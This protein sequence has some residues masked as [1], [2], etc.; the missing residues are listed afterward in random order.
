[1]TK[2]ENLSLLLEAALE[3]VDPYQAVKQSIQLHLPAIQQARK[4]YVVGCGKAVV[5]MALAVEDVLGESITRGV[6][7]TKYGHLAKGMNQYINVLEAAHPVPDRAG[8]EAT[9]SVLDVLREA[10]E[11]DI[12]LALISGG[13]SALWVQPPASVS[14]ED[15]MQV[16]SLLLQSGAAINEMNTVRK[17]LS[18]IKGG[19]A[20]VEAYPARVFAYLISDVVGDALDVI[21]SG[22][23][24]PDST[25]FSDA[26]A[27][28]DRYALAGKMP[29]SVMAHLKDGVRGILPDTPRDGDVVFERVHHEI[30]S[31]NRLAVEAVRIRAEA[32]GYQ[33]VVRDEPLVG[34]A[35]EAAHDFTQHLLSLRGSRPLCFIAGGET[36][37]TLGDTPGKGGRNQEFALAAAAGIDGYAVHVASLATDGNDGPTDAAGAHVDGKTWQG[38]LALG[39]DPEKELHQHN[40]YPLLQACGALLMTGPTNTNVADIQIG[41]VD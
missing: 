23:F 22:P 32:L 2:H 36:T 1:M 34:E 9:T 21:A 33:V 29:D 24:A 40:A 18:C 12:V 30:C 13:G 15:K 39:Y 27:I 31:A 35:V 16:S 17:H 4:V 6:V 14:L 10:Q 5:P 25:S 26:I 19:H 8:I 38:L 28:V 37:V 11:E 20:A 41:L 3:A 7:L